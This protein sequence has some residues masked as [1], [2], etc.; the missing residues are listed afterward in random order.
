M[1]VLFLHPPNPSTQ[2]S[3]PKKAQE[4][5]NGLPY[6]FIGKMV[7]EFAN[8]ILILQSKHLSLHIHNC[9]RKPQDSHLPQQ[10]VHCFIPLLNHRC[11]SSGVGECER[12]S[13]L[14]KAMRIS[15]K[16]SLSMS[17][18]LFITYQC[19]CCRISFTLSITISFSKC[20]K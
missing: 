18:P 12:H 2:I 5:V 6:R 1:I 19:I 16:N 4:G 13:P 8:H 20:F 9:C 3:Q 10:F 11:H 17:L 7:D 15:S 14:P